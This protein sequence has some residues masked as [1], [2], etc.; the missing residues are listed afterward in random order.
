M[1]PVL[2]AAVAAA[3]VV[4]AAA[5]ETRLAP[6][7]VAI[8][9]RQANY[10]RMAAALKGLGEELR[11]ARPSLEQIRVQSAWLDHFGTQVLRWFPRGTGAEAG[12]RT[13]ALPE[14]WSNHAGFTRAGARLVVAVRGVRAAAGR[15]DI[16][17][18]RTFY[19]AVRS[20]CSGCHDD[21]RAPED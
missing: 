8:K 16:G 1:R 21:F 3:L 14:I 19:A 4:T 9:G 20:A 7:G 15:G 10:R 11:A 13:R 2:P 5:A 18:V 17:Q 6:P 12:V